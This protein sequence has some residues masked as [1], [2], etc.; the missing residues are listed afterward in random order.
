[1]ARRT[2]WLSGLILLV[3]M[4]TG[5]G[6]SL[7]TPVPPSAPP[8]SVASGTISKAAAESARQYAA[9]QLGLSPQMVEVTAMEPAQWSDACLGAAQPGEMCA[10]MVTSGYRAT[11]STPQGPVRVHMDQTGRSLRLASTP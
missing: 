7:L 10:Q 11:L 8:N 4:L 9:G 5:C 2:I 3:I 6:L 1:M